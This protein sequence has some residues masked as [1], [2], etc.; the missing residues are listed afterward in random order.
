MATGPGSPTA[1]RPAPDGQGYEKSAWRQGSAAQDGGPCG[2]GGGA[3]AQSTAKRVAETVQK[4]GRAPS[5][6]S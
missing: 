5:D 1:E 6:V 4:D 2:A 3:A